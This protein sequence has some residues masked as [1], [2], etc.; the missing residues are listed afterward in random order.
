MSGPTLV[1]SVVSASSSARIIRSWRDSTAGVVMSSQ[2]ALSPVVASNVASCLASLLSRRINALALSSRPI[3]TPIFTSSSLK[4][5][6][7]TRTSQVLKSSVACAAL[8]STASF[9]AA[10]LGLLV[11]RSIPAAAS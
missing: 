5:R 1:S 4:V 3:E 8:T 10:S 2:R 7:S 11:S 9:P 6:A